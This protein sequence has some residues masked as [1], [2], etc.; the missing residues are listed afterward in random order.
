MSNKTLSLKFKGLTLF[1]LFDSEEFVYSRVLTGTIWSFPFFKSCF[2]LVKPEKKRKR[3]H[4][5]QV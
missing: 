4:L 2:L 3:W 5:S 1:E